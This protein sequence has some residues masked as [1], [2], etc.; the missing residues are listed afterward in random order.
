MSEYKSA[1]IGAERAKWTML[2][3]ATAVALAG[4][5]GGSSGGGDDAGGG[6]S[7]SGLSDA[8]Q[9]VAVAYTIAGQADSLSNL[10]VE[11]SASAGNS[12]DGF[13]SESFTFSA[14]STEEP[15]DDCNAVDDSVDR[16]FVVQSGDA[17]DL[18][19]IDF[20]SPFTSSVNNNL[21]LKADARGR[22]NCDIGQLKALGAY[23]IAQREDIDQDP[24]K[25]LVY[26]RAGGLAGSSLSFDSVAEVSESFQLESSVG[27]VSFPNLRYEMYVCNGCVDGDLSDW[28]G[29]PAKHITSVTFLEMEIGVDGGS[30]YSRLGTID[31]PFVLQSAPDAGGTGDVRVEVNGEYEVTY[32][33]DAE[34]CGLNAKLSTD[35]VGPLYVDSL[36]ADTVTPKRG[37][38]NVSPAGSDKT[39]TV[40]FPAGGGSPL[41]DGRAVD[42][43]D[44]DAVVRCGYVEST[45]I[46]P[47]DVAPDI[48]GTWQ[49]PCRQVQEDSWLN[50][51]YTFN[52]NGTGDAEFAL[53]SDDSCSVN[54]ESGT[55][56]FTYHVGSAVDN[57]PQA[58]PAFELDLNFYEMGETVY[59]LYGVDGNTLFL[60]DPADNPDQEQFRDDRLFM[61]FGYQRQ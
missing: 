51:T 39:F 27:G 28:T 22:A 13:S 34:G 35:E 24:G 54:T 53:F 47:P 8:Q 2:P 56:V 11:Q 10:A 42:E 31:E 25:R 4:C 58:V 23:D 30:T 18:A 19:D 20:P 6:G 9:A 1:R 38:I 59:D 32:G 52:A 15:Y 36:M 37:A 55:N 45:D 12:E 43:D 48:S 14:A 5:G 33:S 29:D 17:L 3:L 50:L 21:G 16:G 44:M 57:S 7:T 49:S 46:A 40:E 60:T 26:A 61:G 41:I